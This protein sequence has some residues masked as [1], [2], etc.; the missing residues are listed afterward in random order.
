MRDY[1]TAK[2][3]DCDRAMRNYEKAMRH[4]ESAK[5]QNG[6]AKERDFKQMALYGH[7]NMQYVIKK[8]RIGLK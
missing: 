1:E 7:H 8:L 5:L 3:R 6:D 4:N 2:Q